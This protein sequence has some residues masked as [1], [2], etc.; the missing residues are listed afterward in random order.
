ML[1]WSIKKGGKHAKQKYKTCV[2]QKA[3]AQHKHQPAKGGFVPTL[4][5]LFMKKSS[6]FM[7][8]AVGWVVFINVR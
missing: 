3:L 8:I 2:M 5:M 6:I 7:M 4:I 1:F